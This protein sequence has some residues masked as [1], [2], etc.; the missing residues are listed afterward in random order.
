MINLTKGMKKQS[1]FEAPALTVDSANGSIPSC[2]VQADIFDRRCYS[3]LVT[4]DGDTG[5]GRRFGW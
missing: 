5:I 2:L 4:A 3:P 1:R